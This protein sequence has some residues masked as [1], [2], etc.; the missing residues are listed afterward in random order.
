MEKQINELYNYVCYS[1]ARALAVGNILKE[2]LI[3][4]SLKVCYFGLYYFKALKE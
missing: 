4:E 3:S 1:N 2:T